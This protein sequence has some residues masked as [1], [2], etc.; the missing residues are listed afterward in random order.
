MSDRAVSFT[1]LTW[2]GICYERKQSQLGNQLLQRRW[3]GAP[4]RALLR[5]ATG[6]HGT[7]REPQTRPV[8]LR[9]HRAPDGHVFVDGAHGGATARRGRRRG[10][11]RSDGHRPEPERRAVVR[12]LAHSVGTATRSGRRV[13]GVSANAL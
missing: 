13:A 11:A 1:P 8:L 2:R 5:R 10:G 4:R 9:A 3:D 12:G 6:R 7:L